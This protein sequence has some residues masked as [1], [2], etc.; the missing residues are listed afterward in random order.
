MRGGAPG[1]VQTRFEDNVTDFGRVLDVM[2][3][4]AYDGWVEI[5]YVHDSRPGCSECDTIQEI[6]AFRTFVLEH[7]AAR[8][9]A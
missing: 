8:E 2:A 6:R 5:E 4:Q 9:R 7:E 1:L 3:E